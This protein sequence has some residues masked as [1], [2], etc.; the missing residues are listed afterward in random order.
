M[1]LLATNTTTKNYIPPPNEVTD[2]QFLTVE[3]TG[4]TNVLSPLHVTDPTPP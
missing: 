4:W 1:I 3:I 2:Q